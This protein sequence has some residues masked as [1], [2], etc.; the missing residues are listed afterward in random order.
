MG[1]HC[2]CQ[3]RLSSTTSSVRPHDRRAVA[4]AR[5]AS[6][7]FPSIGKNR[8]SSGSLG[9][10]RAHP[11]SDPRLALRLPTLGIPTVPVLF[12]SL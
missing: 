3:K 6:R 11:T 8:R 4:D 10:G 9:V 2:F 7:G 1:G 12:G 5:R